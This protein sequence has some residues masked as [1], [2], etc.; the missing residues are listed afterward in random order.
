[1]IPSHKAWRVNE[2]MEVVKHLAEVEWIPLSLIATIFDM[3]KKI[4]HENKHTW[5]K[6][7][8]KWKLRI[9]IKISQI[10]KKPC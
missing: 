6:T 7:E 4:K 5:N 10:K 1:M 2:R 9:L 3:K 8:K